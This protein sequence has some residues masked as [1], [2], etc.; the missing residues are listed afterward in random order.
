MTTNNRHRIYMNF[1]KELY[2][3]L[4][5]QSKIKKYTKAKYMNELLLKEYRI[6]QKKKIDSI[7]EGSYHNLEKTI[8]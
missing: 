8:K 1:P 7:I 6:F 2:D 3:F 5:E 4:S